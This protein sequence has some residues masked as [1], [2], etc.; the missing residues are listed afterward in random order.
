MKLVFAAAGAA[1]VTLTAGVA[2][3]N[4]D[5]GKCFDKGT[6][7]YIDC[8]GDPVVDYDAFYIGAR[9]GAAGVDDDE[10]FDLFE[11]DT[12]VGGDTL[13]IST[14]ADFDVGYIVTAMIGYDNIDLAPSIGFRPELEI[15]YL[16][17][18]S[19]DTQTTDDLD[20]V[21]GG[22]TDEDA[23]AVTDGDITVLFGFA[24]AFVD[25]EIVHGV[26]LFA[27]GGVGFG[28][29]ERDV[30]N[31]EQDD[32][33][34]GYNLGAGID[35]D[36]THDITIEAMYRYM[37]FVDAELVDGDEDT[38]NVHTGTVGVRFKF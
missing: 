27:T 23:V 30:N 1:A 5:S 24:N 9:A 10:D 35:Y 8:P 31:T 12:G 7:T 16:S 17:I 18:D 28:Q 4:G 20:D 36:V 25:F 32:T 29:I 15:G 34:F 19:E 3:A 22:G 37:G 2:A 13:N 26:D 14:N 11:T 33:A 6:L 38:V 21:G